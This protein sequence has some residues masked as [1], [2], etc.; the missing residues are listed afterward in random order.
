MEPEEQQDTSHDDLAWQLVLLCLDIVSIA[1]LS[2]LSVQLRRV[3]QREQL[4]QP[5]MLRDFPEHFALTLGKHRM[6]YQDLYQFG[7]YYSSQHIEVTVSQHPVCLLQPGNPSDDFTVIT[8][9]RK[10]VFDNSVPS[11]SAMRHAGERY[12]YN[13]TIEDQLIAH[14]ITLRLFEM[15]ETNYYASSYILTTHGFSYPNGVLAPYPYR[16]AIAKGLDWIHEHFEVL[17]VN[18]H[19][20]TRMQTNSSDPY[21]IEF[22]GRLKPGNILSPCEQRTPFSYDKNYEGGWCREW[23]EETDRYC[24]RPI[25]CQYCDV[26]HEHPYTEEDR[27][28]MSIVPEEDDR[29]ISDKHLKPYRLRSCYITKETHY[30]KLEPYSLMNGKLI[31]TF[32]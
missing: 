1:R 4:W 12:L 26:C 24:E 29:D 8:Y 19:V 27:V 20:P 10:P 17:T 7:A 6:W 21:C 5:L 18:V 2:G 11:G 13:D 9:R 32:F 25:N 31:P 23:N 3:C 15:R 30:G 22:T 14:G 28:N 16:K